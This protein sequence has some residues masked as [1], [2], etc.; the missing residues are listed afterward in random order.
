MPT[1]ERC[2][3]SGGSFA[4]SASAAVMRS[5]KRSARRSIPARR[6]GR[7]TRPDFPSR[8]FS[9]KSATMAISESPNTTA[10]KMIILGACR[11]PLKAHDLYLLAE[12]LDRRINEPADGLR[13]VF[14]ERRVEQSS[15]AKVRVYLPLDPF[16]PSLRGYDLPLFREPRAGDLQIIPEQVRAKA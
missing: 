12:F 1:L 3:A 14:H 6:A 8:R 10:A 7:Y 9:S 13:R 11:E 2:T 15:C 4:R 5:F 16:R